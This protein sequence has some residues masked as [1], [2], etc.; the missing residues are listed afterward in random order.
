MMKAIQFLITQQIQKAEASTDMTPAT[1][2][3]P[4]L[5][6]IDLKGVP[7]KTVQNRVHSKVWHD[8]R[9][10]LMAKGRTKDFIRKQQLRA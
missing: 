9:N 2:Y 6:Y 3:D 1:E 10:K 8:E 4:I 5:N 7:V